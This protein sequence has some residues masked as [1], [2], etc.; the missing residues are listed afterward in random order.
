MTNETLATVATAKVH[1]GAAVKAASA[2]LAV[3]THDVDV[4]VR[5]TGSLTRGED[6]DQRIVGKADAW[7]LAAALLARLG[8]VDV[9]AVVRDSLSGALKGAVDSLKAEAAA[10]DARAQG[11]D[12]HPLQRQGHHQAV[13]RGGRGRGGA[14]LTIGPSL[15]GVPGLR[16]RAPASLYME[17]YHS[18]VVVGLD[19]SRQP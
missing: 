5:I 19:E 4:L 1:K 18:R 17:D 10:G 8:P 15:A 6:F 3:G 12:S 9:A 7:A 2:E 14:R 13:G 11:R 16:L